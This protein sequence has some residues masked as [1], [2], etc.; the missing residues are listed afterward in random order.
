MSWQEHRRQDCRNS[1]FLTTFSKRKWLKFSGGLPPPGP[2]LLGGFTHTP[3]AV[4]LGPQNTTQHYTA[5]SCTGH[6]SL[7]SPVSLMQ[8]YIVFLGPSK[9]VHGGVGGE[10]PKRGGQVG[11]ACQKISATFSLKS[12]QKHFVFANLFAPSDIIYGKHC[13]CVLCRLVWLFCLLKEWLSTHLSWH[14]LTYFLWSIVPQP[15]DIFCLEILPALAQ[16]IPQVPMVLGNLAVTHCSI[17][18]AVLSSALI[19]YSV[20]D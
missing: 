14:W 4:V 5:P 9:V 3:C 2:S 10:A 20:C 8:C 13:I 11:G 18:A 19:L 6:F 7:D 12:D 17:S 16:S 15:G 1:M